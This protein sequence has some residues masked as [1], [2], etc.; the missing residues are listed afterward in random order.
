MLRFSNIETEIFIKNLEKFCHDYFKDN[1]T[2]AKEMKSLA[3]MAFSQMSQSDSLLFSLDHTIRCAS[4]ALGVV[5]ALTIKNGVADENEFRHILCISLFSQ[6]GIIRG[7]LTEDS[8]HDFIISHDKTVKII[9]PKTDSSLWRYYTERSCLYVENNL[10]QKHMLN[11]ELISESI[12][13]SD[14]TKKPEIIEHKDI[15][16]YARACQI[17]SIFSRRDYNSCIARIYLSAKEAEIL[18]RFHLY[19]LEEFRT[20]FK[21]FFWDHLFSDITDTIAVLRETDEGFEKISSLFKRV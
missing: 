13:Q 18:D 17:I 8:S 21:K 14:F 5:R 16:R 15:I 6:I 3:L 12:R 7:I 19:S 1:Y 10:P 2:V 20:G 4:I 11:I 9:N